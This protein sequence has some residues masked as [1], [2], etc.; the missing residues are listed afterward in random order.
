MDGVLKDL[1]G[2]VVRSEAIKG[3]SLGFE[4][5][6]AYLYSAEIPPS[7]KSI[8]TSSFPTPW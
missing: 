8:S 2:K 5:Y 6:V 3:I 4:E 1:G 7:K